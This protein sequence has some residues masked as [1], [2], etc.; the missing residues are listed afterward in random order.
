MAWETFILL[1]FKTFQMIIWI[2]YKQDVKVISDN[3]Y[4]SKFKYKI[5]DLSKVRT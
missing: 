2:E 4:Y 5:K 1:Y 3:K